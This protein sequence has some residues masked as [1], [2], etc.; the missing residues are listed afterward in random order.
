MPATTQLRR[1][2]TL[3]RD[4]QGGLVS[5]LATKGS[6]WAVASYRSFGAREPYQEG[7]RYGE[8]T[9]CCADQGS[10]DVGAIPCDQ[11]GPVMEAMQT[12]GPA[13]ERNLGVGSLDA[14]VS[15]AE[16]DDCQGVSLGI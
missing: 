5:G 9:A 13:D 11:L 12:E 15:S 10:P 2:P 4:G 8:S 6:V 3:R 14:C 16:N 1:L 7:D